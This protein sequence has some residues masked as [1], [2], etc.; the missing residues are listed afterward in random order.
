MIVTVITLFYSTLTSYDS[1]FYNAFNNLFQKSYFEKEISFFNITEINQIDSF[2]FDNLPYIFTYDK[3]KQQ[4]IILNNN[5]LIKDRL[6]FTIK[7][8]LKKKDFPYEFGIRNVSDDL[9]YQYNHAENKTSFNLNPNLTTVYSMNNSYDSLGGYVFTMDLNNYVDTGNNKTLPSILNIL[10]KTERELLINLYSTQIHSEA[11]LI[12]YEYN[13]LVSLKF[14]FIIDQGSIIEKTI[15]T[16]ILTVLNIFTYFSI[17]TYVFDIFFIVCFLFFLAD[18]INKLKSMESLYERWHYDKIRSLSFQSQEIRS[19][20]NNE[21]FRKLSYLFNFLFLIDLIVICLGFAYVVIRIIYIFNAYFISNTIK[22][23]FIESSLHIIKSYI[24]NETQLKD[25]YIIIGAI[26]IISMSLR[27]LF[28]IDFGRF[29][30]I[31]IK[32]IQKSGDL[33]RIFVIL[34]LLTQPAFVSFSYIAFGYN[35]REYSSW[36]SSLLYTLISLFGSFNLVRLK[37]TTEELGSLFF[38]LYIIIINLILI[39]L[40]VVTLDRGYILVKSKIKVMTEDYDFKYVFCFCCYKRKLIY[41]YTEHQL[42]SD[43]EKERFKVPS[44]INIILLETSNKFTFSESENI[45]LSDIDSYL[46]KE[47]VKWEIVEKAYISIKIGG[48]VRNIRE[49]LYNDLKQ[50]HRVTS[51]IFIISN[52]NK[53]INN[54]EMNLFHIERFS[55]HMENYYSYQRFNL[56]LNDIKHENLRQIKDIEELE[57][58]FYIEL[59]ELEKYQNVNKKII[60]IEKHNH[61]IRN[62]EFDVDHTSSYNDNSEFD[63]VDYKTKSLKGSSNLKG[64]KNDKRVKYDKDKYKD[65]SV[66]NESVESITQS[67][68]ESKENDDDGRSE[69]DSLNY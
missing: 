50:E 7:R 26:L 30:G 32:T 64:G 31:V 27:L 40:F 55:L 22:T 14:S 49:S 8:N 61:S 53:V 39:N 33:M 28:L 36:A 5:V 17:I 47:L 6:I 59:N 12:N 1:F 48:I 38:Y 10:N 25:C 42:Y 41:Q 29:F 43:Y 54:M 51:G 37:S 65:E 46:L 69:N 60:E 18:F 11:L 63:Y 23:R 57:A 68:E 2:L 20:F 67:E 45:R 66:D 62:S 24:N 4:F 9:Y 21:V 52:L 35:L 34:L 15:H 13:M 56:S 3:S 58:E 19:H 44:D 16:K